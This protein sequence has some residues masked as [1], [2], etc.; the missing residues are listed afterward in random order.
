MIDSVRAESTRQRKPSLP[1]FERVT[2]QGKK[3]IDKRPQPPSNSLES[4]KY[5]N[6][7][8]DSKEA[9]RRSEAK[10]LK[11]STKPKVPTLKELRLSPQNSSLKTDKMP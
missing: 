9:D 7:T 5:R 2:N 8:R 6:L 10:N 4:C 1:K 3:K 11:P